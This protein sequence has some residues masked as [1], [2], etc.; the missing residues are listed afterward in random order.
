[1]TIL[2]TTISARHTLKAF[3]YESWM[4]YL[5]SFIDCVGFYC[6]FIR[7]SMLST[8]VAKD[9]LGKVMAFTSAFDSILP[10]GI[11]ALYK[12][13]FDVSMKSQYVGNFMNATYLSLSGHQRF[14]HWHRVPYLCGFLHSGFYLFTLHFIVTKRTTH[15]WHSRSWKPNHWATRKREKIEIHFQTWFGKNHFYLKNI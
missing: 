12:N 10:I 1:M 9:E 3:S 13:V 6:M 4:Y 5:A 7:S 15:V 8:I 11:S 2:Y 14:F